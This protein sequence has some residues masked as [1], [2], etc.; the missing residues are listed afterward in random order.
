MPPE[1]YIEQESDYFKFSHIYMG[2]NKILVA[3]FTNNADKKDTPEFA[4]RF[5]GDAPLTGPDQATV[6]ENY[7]HLRATN[8]KAMKIAPDETEKAQKACRSYCFS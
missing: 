5:Y 4:E 7:L 3:I 2:S 6:A 1:K 8:M